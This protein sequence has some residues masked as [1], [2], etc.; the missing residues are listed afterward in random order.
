MAT[1]ALKSIGDALAD[2]VDSV[3]EQ[4]A[5]D[6]IRRAIAEDLGLQ[7]G[8]AVPPAELPQ[9][10]LD[11][12]AR[13]RSQANPDKEA[14]V[15]LLADV[16]AIYE[17]CRSFI[18]AFGAGPV[19][20]HNELLYRMFDL[21][22]VN[23]MRLK[24]PRE[25]FLIQAI[26]ALVDGS[27]ELVEREAAFARVFDTLA[28]VVSF[29]LSPLYYLF[30]TM[31]AEDEAA[32]RRVSEGIF[33]HLA[34]FLALSGITDE[35]IYGWDAVEGSRQP[36]AD[37]IAARA[38]TV[39][40]PGAA[41]PSAGSDLA[42]ALALTLGVIPASAAQASGLLVSVG[43]AGELAIALGERW[44]FRLAASA[45]P[46]FS[47]FLDT[48]ARNL[49]GHGPTSAPLDVALL[50]T[51]DADNV[52]FAI[53]D[54]EGT[55]LEIG[56]LAFSFGFNGAT[57][58][59]SAQ[60]R[61]CALVIATGDQDSFLARLLP[62]DGLRVPFHFGFGFSSERRFYSEGDIEWPGGASPLGGGLPASAAGGLVLGA[63]AAGQV[64]ALA[65]AGS[66]ELGLQQ[67]IPIGKELLGTRLTQLLLALG[68]A[69]DPAAGKATAEVSVALALRL[70]P[71]TA[72]V[73]RVGVELSLAFPTSGGNAGFADLSMGLKQPAGV[74]ITVDSPFVAGGGFL[75]FDRAKGQYAGV[76][77]LTINELLTVTSIGVISTRLP[78]GARGFAF[79][80]LITAEHFRPVPLGLGF[81][82]TGIGGLLAINR[83]VNEEVLREGIKNQTLDHL[84]FPQDPVGNAAQIFAALNSAFPPRD[85]SYL[86]GPV[87]Q[88]RWGSPP[89]LTMDLGLVLELGN[90]RRL[91]ILGRVLA[92]MPSERNDLLRLQMNA[93]GVVDF[94]QRSIALDAVLY[95]SRL[96]GKFPI[97]GA[98][99]LRLRWGS[100]PTFALAI[101][102]FHPA[103]RPPAGMPALARLAISFSNTDSFR[104]RA[105]TY[106]ALT[107]N[108]LQFGAKAELFA[109]AGG[110]SVEGRLGYDVLIQFDPFGFLADF[111]ASLQL[112]R[113]SRNL[114]KVKLE[115]QLAGPRPLRVRA[116]ATFEILWCDFSISIDRTLVAGEPPPRPEPVVVLARLRAALADRR[117]WSSQSGA[118]ERRVAVLREPAGDLLVLHP[119]GGLAVKQTVV[120]L[121]VTIARFG[122]SVPADGQ[123]FRITAMTVNDTSLSFTGLSDFFAPAQFLELSDAEKLAAP[124]FE[125]MPAGV[126]AG[127][128]GALFPTDDA[129]I[130]EEPALTYETRVIDRA[131]G[132]EQ[133][134]AP[135]TLGPAALARQLAL[136]AAARSELRQ[137]GPARY[138]AAGGK[139]AVVGTAWAVASALDGSPQAAPGLAAGTAASYAEAFQALEALRRARPAQARGLA[140][141]RVARRQGDDDA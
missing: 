126:S 2:F 38:L 22:A 113:G 74:G 118:G 68:P 98:M 33:P 7:P 31:G 137:S 104:L 14:F 84:L 87:V 82:L 64:P 27:A 65:G 122:A 5:D 16:R 76:V 19:S 119:L 46:A 105:E 61:R 103:F 114:F 49:T 58:Q 102:G 28:K 59:I 24:Y 10:S 107:A 134:A 57:G 94:D 62:S 75:F 54:A 83:T 35:V 73:D 106:F 30:K 85:G 50:S 52:T 111:F 99:A 79:V 69:S 90:R 56:Q 18:A 125:A 97:T 117:S 40:F 13:Y 115:G 37:A 140:L 141:V 72:S 96:A 127:A 42:G 100:D 138:R 130:L 47:I 53:P 17:A 112:K 55:R 66:P 91:I 70:G 116:R 95:D 124:S 135:Y 6:L 86:F 45:E 4:L 89:V 132:P 25:Y 67:V 48:R 77:Q 39:A 44:Q 63:G 29:A 15:T 23:Y 1:S 36:L 21:L 108:T 88:I 43:G 51:P 26:G 123:V 41:A 80:L 121:G 8:A 131:R 71:V 139:N 101:G 12:A 3:R 133:S 93:L 92:I 128:G 9:A 136:G 60:A 11:G 129:D 20:V 110:F 34:A 120:P 109:R 81:T 32:A 78:G